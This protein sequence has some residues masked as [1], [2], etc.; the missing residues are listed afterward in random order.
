VVGIDFGGKQMN[1]SSL[2]VFVKG[3]KA[4]QSLYSG[5]ASLMKRKVLVTIGS[6]KKR[7]IESFHRR[8]TMR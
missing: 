7:K 3:G 4:T 1:L 8:L 2:L 6:L 5:A